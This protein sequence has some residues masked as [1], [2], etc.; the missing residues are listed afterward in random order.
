MEM[1]LVHGVA[2]LDER[3][4]AVEVDRRANLAGLLLLHATLLHGLGGGLGL[5]NGVG[6]GFGR[7]GI[8]SIYNCGGKQNKRHVQ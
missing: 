8:K 3:L 4:G 6:L 5:G 1:Y 7:W 2:L